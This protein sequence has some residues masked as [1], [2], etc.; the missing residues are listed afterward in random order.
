LGNPIRESAPDVDP[1]AAQKT[2]GLHD[3]VLGDQ[4][5]CCAKD[6]PI[7]AT[8]SARPIITHNVPFA[9]KSSTVHQTKPLPFS[10]HSKIQHQ[11]VICNRFARIKLY[12]EQK[13]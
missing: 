12:L 3:S 9:S 1:L 8:A 10:K 13:K 7:T 4:T 5:A 6:C 2:V 11:F